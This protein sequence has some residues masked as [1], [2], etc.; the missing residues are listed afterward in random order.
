MPVIKF[1]VM[2]FVFVE[3]KYLIE[4][5]TRGLYS[6][7]QNRVPNYMEIFKTTIGS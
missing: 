3:E 5:G 2:E 7:A 6:K 4:E 1:Q